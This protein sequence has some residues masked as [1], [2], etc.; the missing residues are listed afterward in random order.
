MDVLT[1]A[2]GIHRVNMVEVEV[3][4]EVDIV[5][6]VTGVVWDSFIE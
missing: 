4:V 3:E 1:M 6:M 5:D 2:I